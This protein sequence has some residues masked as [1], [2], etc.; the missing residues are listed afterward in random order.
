MNTHQRITK[1]VDRELESG[2]SYAFIT[3]RLM[4]L[5]G[6]SLKMLDSVELSD[7]DREEVEMIKSAM[8]KNL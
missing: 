7:W 2:A 3:G 5:L 6:Q 1:M 8:G 4:S